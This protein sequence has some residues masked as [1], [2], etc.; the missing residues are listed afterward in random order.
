MPEPGGIASW[1]GA[2]ADEPLARHSQYGIGGPADWFVK[3]DDAMALGD[4]L[5]LANAAGLPVTPIGAGSNT[6]ILDGGIRGVVV[7]I[8]DKAMRVI[9]DTVIELR[10]GCMLPRVALD[11]AR[12]G[13][14]GL[15]FGIGIPGTCG[16]SIRGN[17]GAFGR[18]IKDVLLECSALDVQGAMRT[19]SALECQ[20]AYRTS[21][22][23]QSLTDSIVVA[24][25]FGVTPNTAY[26]VRRRTAAIQAHRKSTQPYGIRSLG[27]VFTNPPGDHAGRLVEAVGLKGARRGGAEIS[28]VHANFI[29]NVDRATA[30]DV[31][32]LVELAHD[33]VLADFGVDLVREIVV[34]GEDKARSEPSVTKRRSGG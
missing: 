15:E 34:M 27:S 33:R 23:K 14:A 25:R 2:R 17:A 3:V 4:L 6:L 8:T 11:C 19:F 21:I 29:V 22:F 12:L 28:T 5:R 26:A 16:A 1:P 20:F 10:A 24:A 18:E 32:D 9:D 7:E 31:L 13:L 30:R